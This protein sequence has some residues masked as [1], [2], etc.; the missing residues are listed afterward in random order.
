[1]VLAHMAKQIMCINWGIRYGVPY[2]NRLYAIVARHIT[3]PFRFVCYTDVTDG[4][5]AE[6]ITKDLPPM[7]GFMPKHTKG[8]WPKSRLWAPRLDGLDGTVLFLDLDVAITGSLDPFFEFGDPE[9]V[10]LA[11]NAA[12]P[13]HKLG[14][15]SI[16]RMPVGK[17]A[18]L[19]EAF[20]ADPQGIADRYRFEQHFVTKAAPGG[21]KFWPKSWVR[22][23]RIECARTFPLNF[24]LP[25]RLP[26]DA[27]VVIFAGHPN[28]PDAMEGRMSADLPHLPPLAHILRALS[29]PKPMK[30][31]RSY[32]KPAEWV[33]DVADQDSQSGTRNT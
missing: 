14:Q 23:F 27:R 8:K 17:L 22:H 20:A 12:K 1:M 33:W 5:R 4:V 21:V 29:Q 30:A 13:L 6:V 7:P 31:I 18:P 25:P 15:T 16:Y 28:P 24:V 3:P 2:I 32:I 19:Q 10:I 26:R 9:D 11:R